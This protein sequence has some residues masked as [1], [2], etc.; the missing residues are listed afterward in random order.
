M[1]TYIPTPSDSADVV[2]P[3]L[4]VVSNHTTIFGGFFNGIMRYSAILTYSSLQLVRI[5]LSYQ[6]ISYS[7]QKCREDINTVV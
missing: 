2:R 4:C 3:N 1:D 6:N 5:M 7:H